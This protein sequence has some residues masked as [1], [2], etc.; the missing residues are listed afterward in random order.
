MI[1]DSEIKFMHRDKEKQGGRKSNKKR[2]ICI[3]ALT[4]SS[5][6]SSPP[7]NAATRKCHVKIATATHWNVM[8]KIQFQMETRRSLA[9]VIKISLFWSRYEFKFNN[10]WNY[11]NVNLKWALFMNKF[12]RLWIS[13][14][15]ALTHLWIFLNLHALGKSS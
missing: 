8:T 9:F 14:S 13:A 15:G 7:L 5:I 1:K 10:F 4:P 12:S 2:H 11:H 6:S 3:I